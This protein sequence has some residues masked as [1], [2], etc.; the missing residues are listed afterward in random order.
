MLL[1]TVIFAFILAANSRDCVWLKNEEG[2]GKLTSLM[3]SPS[4]PAQFHF[5]KENKQ[6]KDIK[7]HLSDGLDPSSNN[8]TMI[9]HIGNNTVF[10]SAWVNFDNLDLNV[11][12]ASSK[13]V[14]SAN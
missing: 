1:L 4:G 14:D 3:S 12:L 9:I 2:A 8:M 10:K 7:I 5:N 11:L 6:A 13:D